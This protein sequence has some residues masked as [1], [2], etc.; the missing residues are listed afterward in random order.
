MFD[1]SF[2]QPVFT[3]FHFIRP[4]W[5]LAFIPLLL[6][7]SFRWKREKKRQNAPILPAHLKKVLTVGEPKWKRQLP[8]KILT[9]IS[10]LAVIICAGPSWLREPSPFGEDK[11][12]LVIVLDVSDSMLQRD[13]AP[14]RLERAKQKIKDLLVL[15]GGGKTGLVVYSGS[16]HLAMPLTQDNLVFSPILDAIDASVMPKGGKFAHLALPLIEQQLTGF[17]SGG[18]VLLISDAANTQDREQ[19]NKLFSDS[20][21]QL[22][23]LAMGNNNRTSDLPMNYPSLEALTEA[24]NGGIIEVTVS[25]E[26][27]EWLDRQVE[28][29]M[30]LSGDLAMPWMD[31]GY[32]LLYP[33]AFIL[34][35][36]FRRGWLVQWCLAL[37]LITPLSPVQ[38][39]LVQHSAADA[40]ASVAL[41]GR[42]KWLQF[43]LDLWLTPDQQGQWYFNQELYLKAAQH[44]Q[45][46]MRKGVAFFFAQEYKLAHS[47]FLQVDSDAAR[48]NITNALIGQREYVAARDRLI[49]ILE[50]H[51]DNQNAQTNLEIIQAFIDYINEFSESQAQSMEGSSES[52]TELPDN[53]PQTADGVEEEVSSDRMKSESISAE[54]ILN[55]Q[56][57]A[58][59]WLK[60]VE[61][62]PKQFLRNKFQ[63]QLNEDN[64]GK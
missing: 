29:H 23:I 22:L 42:E 59:K 24:N 2:W 14:S 25:S 50:A 64:K 37:I 43:W 3:H 13:V 63:I 35:L 12:P 17:S 11:A 40:S 53:Q 33:L 26:D 41:T 54:Q 1:L 32:Y 15:R 60:R 9:L 16:A 49:L 19:F 4:F 46:P 5:L 47:A 38:A 56:A 44:Y 36:W 8:L 61:A 34:L 39:T 45:D 31:M 21:H 30:Q 55:D 10:T 51:P 27:V 6:L 48:F 18:S 7:I 20:P 28:R 52:S 58:E 62:N 57:I